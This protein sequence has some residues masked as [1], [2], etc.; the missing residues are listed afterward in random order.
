MTTNLNATLPYDGYIP[1]DERNF[2]SSFLPSML[3]AFLLTLVAELGDK[4]FIMLIILQLKANKSTV[5]CSSLFAQIGMNSI[6]IF[7]GYAVDY[8]LYKNFIDYIG[9][10]FFFVYSIWLIGESLHSSDQSFEKD[11]D[12][13]TQ[14]K[15]MHKRSSSKIIFR[16]LTP[17]PETTREDSKNPDDMT[18]PLLDYK[19]FKESVIVEHPEEEERTESAETK[20]FWA[21]FLS[22]TLSECGDRTQVS[23]LTM[24]AIYDVYG[25]LCGSCAALVCTV[26]LG[27]FFGKVVVK[28]LHEKFLNLVLGVLFFIYAVEIYMRKNNISISF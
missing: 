19:N 16:E 18:T 24:A 13:F 3:H 7:I 20:M 27:V 21:I 22:M 23:S 9:I 6:A 11:L 2:S 1:Y 5:L 10:L 4:T 25:V 8:M 17:I 14:S 26:V 28:H 15:Q 12:V